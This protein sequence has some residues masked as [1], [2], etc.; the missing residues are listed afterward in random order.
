M[1]QHNA[2]YVLYY[3]EIINTSQQFDTKILHLVSWNTVWSAFF[4]TSTCY[5]YLQCYG[6]IFQHNTPSK[7]WEFLS[8][9]QWS[10]INR[11]SMYCSSTPKLRRTFYSFQ[12]IS[13]HSNTSSSTASVHLL[14]YLNWEEIVT[15]SVYSPGHF[16]SNAFIIID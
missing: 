6:P 1:H 11:A 2:Q 12:T 5:S 13:S 3:F 10:I 8:A 9:M 4:R 7:L 16:Y 15:N 14:R